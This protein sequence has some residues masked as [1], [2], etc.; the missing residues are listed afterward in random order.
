MTGTTPPTHP[1]RPIENMRVTLWGVQGSF[2]V[3]PTP[4]GV[5]EY[6][7]R[8]GYHIVSQTLDLMKYRC[9]DGRCS[10]EELL[11]GP[12]TPERVAEFQ[13]EVGLPT[14][15]IYGGETTCIQVETNEGNVILLDAGSGIRRCSLELA[16]RW[17]GRK[18]RAVHLFASHEHTDHRSGLA[19]ARFNYVA[20]DPYTVHIYGSYGF[21]RAV[22]VHYGIFSHQTTELTYVDD[23]LDFTYMKATFA[24]TE[25]CRDSAAEARR[26]RHWAVRDLSPVKVGGTT[27]TPFEVY[28]VIPVCLGYRIEHNGKVFVFA[29]DHELRRGND[30]SD[31]RQQ[32][33]DAAERTLLQ[34][35]RGADLAYYD[36]QYYRAEYEGSKAIGSYPAMPR[37]DWGHSCIEDVVERAKTARVK[38]TLIGHHDPDRTWLERVEIDEELA[39]QCEGKAYRIQL[40]EG[41]SVFDL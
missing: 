13:R 11:G 33:S 20:D 25:F 16:L 1:A 5:Q 19:F 35:S 12:V 8:L 10:P 7:R 3:F 4:Y 39:K 32:R 31:P 14:L 24:G 30:P 34:M 23:P 38:H 36:G 6:A 28:H 9:P 37:M 21:L 40:A 29:T 15:P 27:I 18:N 26:D 17:D 2:P 41:D 22:D